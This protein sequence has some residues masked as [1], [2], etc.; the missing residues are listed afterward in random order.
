MYHLFF[1]IVI[2]FTIRKPQESFQTRRLYLAPLSTGVVFSSFDVWELQAMNLSIYSLCF[3]WKRLL[4]LGRQD[5]LTYHEWSQVWQV[6]NE[7][8]C[9]VQWGVQ[10]SGQGFRPPGSPW[11][12]HMSM[13]DT[14]AKVLYAQQ[15]PSRDLSRIPHKGYGIVCLHKRL[16]KLYMEAVYAH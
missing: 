16:W 14:R 1:F 7:S 2:V 9:R 4:V 15:A 3:L 6:L 11:K 12:R 10:N 5:L 13:C 8:Y